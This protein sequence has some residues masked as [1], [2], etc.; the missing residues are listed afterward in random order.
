MSPR[1]EPPQDDEVIRLR[2]ENAK[3]ARIVEQ[4]NLRAA[5]AETRLDALRK[6]LVEVVGHNRVNQIERGVVR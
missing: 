5:S 4:A 1:P 3:L 6:A 2:V